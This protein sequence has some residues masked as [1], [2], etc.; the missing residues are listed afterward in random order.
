LKFRASHESEEIPA[1]KIEGR[2]A[3]RC[4]VK[5]RDWFTYFKEEVSL[6]KNSK[7]EKELKKGYKTVMTFGGS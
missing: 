5:W 2:A 1:G 7:T 4:Q 6:S 3:V